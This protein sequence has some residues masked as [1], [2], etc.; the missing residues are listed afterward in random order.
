M[1]PKVG[2]DSTP[3]G[4]RPLSVLAV[5]FPVLFI[6]LVMVGAL[7]RLGI[8]LLL[9]LKRSLLVLLILMFISLLLTLLSLS[10][11][12]IGV[13]WRGFWAVLACLPGSVIPIL[14]IMLM[15]GYV[16]KLAAG[17]GST[18]DSGW[19]YPSMLSSEYDVHSCTLS[20]LVQGS[21]PNFMLIILSVCL[22]DP[23]L[24]LR[25]AKFAT[26]YVRLVG[27]EPAPSKCVSL[28]IFLRLF[29]LRC[30]AGFFLMRAISG[31]SSW[32][33]EIWA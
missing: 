15:F 28:S 17:L 14:S 1:I 13:F 7:L 31:L 5:V 10:I 6:V 11:R 25:A 12:L 26:G 33:F 16:F 2:G 29:V 24:L 32:M 3:L 8:L 23:D 27:Q 19:W 9:I 4:Q 21:R 30:V 22:R 20:F 18:F